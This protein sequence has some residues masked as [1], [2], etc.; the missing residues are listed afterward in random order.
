MYFKGVQAAAEQAA[1]D[2]AA[3]KALEEAAAHAE[4]IEKGEKKV[5]CVELGFHYFSAC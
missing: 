3:A 4:A 2:A 5:S 1:A